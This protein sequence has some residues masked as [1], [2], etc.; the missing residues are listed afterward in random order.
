MDNKQIIQ[1][2]KK[3]NKWDYFYSLLLTGS[4]EGKS[5]SVLNLLCTDRN[6]RKISS[7][8]YLLCHGS[9][10]QLKNF[11]TN[12]VV[13]DCRYKNPR[14]CINNGKKTFNLQYQPEFTYF[15]EKVFKVLVAARLYA[16]EKKTL[17]PKDKTHTL[18]KRILNA[19]YTICT[20]YGDFKFN[21]GVFKSFP[22][23]ESQ[24]LYFNICN[25]DYWGNNYNKHLIKLA[26]K[27][28]CKSVINNE[29][30]TENDRFW[31]FWKLS[32]SI[33]D[34]TVLLS[35]IPCIDKENM[36]KKALLQVKKIERQKQAIT[37]LENITHDFLDKYNAN[38]DVGKK[39][40]AKIA[41]KKYCETQ[42]KLNEAKSILNRYCYML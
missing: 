20:N 6:K 19:H 25:N 40:E 23:K 21:S 18:A 9:A 16:F 5:C 7:L 29:F 10:K 42:D 15:Y 17:Y 41:W 26:D 34:N 11:L 27:D 4:V 24:A 1:I 8:N 2:L 35:D 13:Y 38:N 33:S 31:C 22:N 32:Y 28:V 36:K 39:T 30:A 37:K 14:R 12:P 3:F